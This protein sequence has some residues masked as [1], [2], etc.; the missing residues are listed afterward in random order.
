MVVETTQGQDFHN[1][2]ITELSIK[3]SSDPK[4]KALNKKFYKE[5][6]NYLKGVRERQKECLQFQLSMFKIQAEGEG[7]E[8]NI[9]ELGESESEIINSSCDASIKYDIQKTKNETVINCYQNKEL[10]T[11]NEDFSDHFL[12]SLIDFANEENDSV[13]EEEKKANEEKANELNEISQ[14]CKE[15]KLNIFYD[16]VGE[17][18]ETENGS[19]RVIR[20][21]FLQDINDENDPEEIENLMEQILSKERMCRY[22]KALDILDE[23]Y[24]LSHGTFDYS[25]AINFAVNVFS[26]KFPE[27]RIDAITGVFENSMYHVYSGNPDGIN[28]RIVDES[29]FET[30]EKREWYPCLGGFGINEF[31][32]KDEISKT[33]SMDKF[34]YDMPLAYLNEGVK[35]LLE[36]I[37]KVRE[38]YSE[39]AKAAAEV[40]EEIENEPDIFK[41][42]IDIDGVS[43]HIDTIMLLSNKMECV[44]IPLDFSD[45][46]RPI[47]CTTYDWKR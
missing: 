27:S 7:K 42:H 19:K 15:N 22:F 30:D 35:G 43:H 29:F 37:H 6:L 12:E 31:P 21:A 10:I 26:E 39:N 1:I 34:Y 25:S 16:I 18:I 33:V 41:P 28:E 46:E 44:E 24:T 13:S 45:S 40:G 9:S 11:N 8:L 23:V 38:M 14:S 2:S 17:T 20:E 4:T 32:K 47:V 3:N 5:T 36:N